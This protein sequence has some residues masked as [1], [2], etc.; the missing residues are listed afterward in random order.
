VTQ[1]A[2]HLLLALGLKEKLIHKRSEQMRKTYIS[3]LVLLF[4]LP[5]IASAHTGIGETTGFMHGFGHPIGGLD[6]ILAMVAVGLWASQIG[7]RSIWIVPCTF[8]GVMCLGGALG[9]S[10]V[11]IPFVEE[12]ILL[13]IL[14]L[15]VLIAGAFKL[16]LIYSSL[17]VGLFAIF[18]GHAHGTEMPASISAASYAFGFA[19][20]T[21]ILHISGIGLGVLMQKANLQVVSR[22]AGGAIALS[23]IFLAVS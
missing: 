10:G 3:L 13:S 20:V 8:V 9:F 16:P 18:H 7:S 4:A 6:H 23:G 14:V 19:L 22:I 5:S 21:A 17:I 2:A 1:K 15:G 11:S 12:G